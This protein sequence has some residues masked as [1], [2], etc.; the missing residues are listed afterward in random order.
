MHIY[1]IYPDI[2]N[3]K[4]RI[5]VLRECTYICVWLMYN[6]QDKY[7]VEYCITRVHEIFWRN[8]RLRG[9]IRSDEIG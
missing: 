5:F 1:K 4:V 7:I 2:S 3:S 6:K 8:S 9:E